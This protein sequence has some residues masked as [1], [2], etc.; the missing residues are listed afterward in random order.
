MVARSDGGSF[1]TGRP[2][3]CDNT[4][5]CAIAFY[6]RAFLI[7]HLLSS[8]LDP[9][10]GVLTRHCRDSA[11]LRIATQRNSLAIF[12]DGTICPA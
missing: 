4:G 2:A 6:L 3:Y 1:S 7:S 9:T 12:R 10:P 8:S 11:S 5:L